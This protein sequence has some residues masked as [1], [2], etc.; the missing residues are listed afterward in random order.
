MIGQCKAAQVKEKR[1]PDAHD[2]TIRQ[3][4]ECW[5]HPDWLANLSDLRHT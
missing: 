5:D 1:W 4:A 3:V 2:E